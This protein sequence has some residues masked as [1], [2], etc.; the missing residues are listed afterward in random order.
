MVGELRVAWRGG[1]EAVC[2]CCGTGFLVEVDTISGD[3]TLSDHQMSFFWIADWGIGPSCCATRELFVCH[4]CAVDHVQVHCEQLVGSSRITLQVNH[5]IVTFFLSKYMHPPGESRY[6]AFFS[7][8]TSAGFSLPC[9]R[10]FGIR[11]AGT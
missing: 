7:F 5:I 11:S 9:N 10:T 2:V 6:R 3:I 4:R 1:G 8:R